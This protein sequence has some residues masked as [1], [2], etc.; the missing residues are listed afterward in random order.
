MQQGEGKPRSNIWKHVLFPYRYDAH[1]HVRNTCQ[2]R[3]KLDINIVKL[4]LNYQA[5]NSNF[6]EEKSG[7]HPDDPRAPTIFKTM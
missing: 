6:A 2:N 4:L 7:R 3:D 1:S 5:Q